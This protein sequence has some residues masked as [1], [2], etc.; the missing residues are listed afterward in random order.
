MKIKEG[1]ILRTVAGQNVVVPVGANTMNFN[2]AITLND[3]AAFLWK[4]LESEKNEQELLAALTNEYEIDSA[5]AKSDITVF[6]NVLREHEIL[7]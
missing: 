7:E 2:V 5:T 3:S 4:Q 1:F 6:L